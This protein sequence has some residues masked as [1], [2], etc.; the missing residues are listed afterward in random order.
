MVIELHVFNKKKKNVLWTNII[1][2]Q[3][4]FDMFCDVKSLNVLK[5]KARTQF[6]NIWGGYN[7]HSIPYNKVLL[8]PVIWH[9]CL[10]NTPT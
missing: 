10:C 2:A 1:G 4:T 5:L 9:A 7:N 8:Y 3:I 6:P